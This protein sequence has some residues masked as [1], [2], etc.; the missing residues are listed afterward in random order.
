VQALNGVPFA[1]CAFG[2]LAHQRKGESVTMPLTEL[3]SR[4]RPI[5]RARIEEGSLPCDIPPHIYAGPGTGNSCDLCGIKIAPDEIEYE[6]EQL[7]SGK[8]VLRF[9]ILC[10]SIWQLECARRRH[11]DK[12]SLRR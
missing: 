11:L 4:L 7:S 10:E 9:H 3:E 8:N 5:A 2:R 12:N 1:T 6:L